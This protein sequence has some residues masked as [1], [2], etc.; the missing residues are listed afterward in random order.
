MVVVLRPRGTEWKA[1]VSA[2]I[3][4]QGYPGRC[5]PWNWER[6]CDSY[7]RSIGTTCAEVAQIVTIGYPIADIGSI[8]CWAQGQASL[9]ATIRL[10]KGFLVLSAHVWP[11]PR[12]LSTVSLRGCLLCYD[13]QHCV[14]QCYVMLDYAIQCSAILC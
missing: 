11:V 3:G 13:L 5:A 7:F 14:V 1:N 8:T 9:D 4:R 6:Q 2:D 10:A 12:D